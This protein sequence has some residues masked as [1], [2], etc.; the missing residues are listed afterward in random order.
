[1][2]YEWHT[3][4]CS[5]CGPMCTA[6]RPQE[7]GGEKDSARARAVL[8]V[9][10]SSLG[11]PLYRLQ[12]SQAMLGVPVP[13][14]TQWDQ[15]ETVG[16]GRYAV[17]AS[18]ETLA[19]QGALLSHDDTSVRMLSLMAANLTMQAQ[20][21]AMGVSRPRERTGMCTT[22]VVVTVGERTICLYDSGR[23]HAGEHLAALLE[24]R[25]AAQ[26]TPVVMSDA[27]ARHEVDATAV[28]RCH[29]L[30]HGR[31]Q[32]RDRADVFPTECQGVLD[33]L[34]QGCDHD[35]EARDK[36]MSPAARL[37]SHQEYR[38]PLL[39]ERK[40]WLDTQLDDHLVEPKSALGK[41]MAS[42]QSH[43][44]TLTRCVAV[45]GAPLDNPL[46]ERAV[47]LGIRQRTN[48]LCDTT[49]SSASIAS[50]LTSLMAT[51]RHAGVTRLDALVALHERRAE[52]CAEPSAWLPWTS[53]ARVAP[54]EATRRQSRA[55]CA[56]SGSP[57]H[58][59]RTSSRAAKGTRAAAVL[60]HQVTRP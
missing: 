54:P 35:A 6:S 34:T 39:D 13:D 46:V 7:A 33:G 32:C 14:A 59:T 26:G 8:A 41:A 2:R 37:A 25:Q 24:K 58:S 42:R 27:L 9:C 49:P 55:I 51:C 47:Q 20:A 38:R 60:G 12:G 40:G 3:L 56:R 22:A 11:V 5:A 43:W 19:A 44:E 30:A 50:G 16:D 48:A 15:I 21:E 4:R 10:R 29:C 53:Q 36:P 17:L 18:L 28:L 52:V 45:V 31:R 1:M 57:C 23:A